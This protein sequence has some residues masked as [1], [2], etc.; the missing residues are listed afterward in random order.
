MIAKTLAR[1]IHTGATRWAV[2]KSNL[3][4]L[5]KKTGYTF[6]NCKKALE[7]H[8]NDITKVIH[9]GDCCKGVIWGV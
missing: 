4:V 1:F 5:R 6:A 3:A 8:N 9:G 2:E 7:L